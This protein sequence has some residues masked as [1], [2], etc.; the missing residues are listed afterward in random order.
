MS[1]SNSAY[2]HSKEKKK[3]IRDFSVIYFILQ[4]TTENI[5][6][7]SNQPNKIYIK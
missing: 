7:P 6:H 5:Q 3:K 4:E 1:W 2:A